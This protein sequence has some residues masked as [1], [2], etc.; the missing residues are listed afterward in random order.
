MRSLSDELAQ[1]TPRIIQ[2]TVRERLGRASL[3]ARGLETILDSF[4]TEIALLHGSGLPFLV[5]FGFVR[6]QRLAVVT[7]RV[8]RKEANLIGAGHNAS[9]AADTLALIHHHQVVFFP[10]MAGTGRTNGNTGRIH[11]MIAADG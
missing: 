4:N 10:L 3:N 8:F 9:A 1:I 6:S 11:T 5:A 7:A 2:I